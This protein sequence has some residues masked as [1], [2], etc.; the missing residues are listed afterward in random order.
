LTAAGQERP[1]NWRRPKKQQSELWDRRGLLGN[2]VVE[3]RE[4]V[5]KRCDLMKEATPP[6]AG[7]SRKSGDVL[8]EAADETMSAEIVLGAQWFLR[9][10]RGRRS[11][12]PT[13]PACSRRA[14]DS[15]AARRDRC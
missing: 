1:S 12:S 11:Q 5:R 4:I 15:S 2:H 6:G 8:R 3:A 13:A 7:D 9:P 10:T 14:T